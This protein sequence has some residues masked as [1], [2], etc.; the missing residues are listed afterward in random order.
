MPQ[1]LIELGGAG[2]LL[3][4]APA[5]GFPPA[6]YQPIAAALADS[7]RSVCL[8]PR[9]LWGGEPPSVPGNWPE[10][11]DDIVR[12]LA[13]HDLPP[14]IAIG[15]SFGAVASLVAAVR[16]P[17]RFRALVLLD[18][19]VLTGPRLDDWGRAKLLGWPDGHP[20]ALRA[21]E[22]R[23]RFGSHREAFDYWRTKRLFADW[24][25]AALEGYVAAMLVPAPDG[26]GFVLAWPKAWEAYYYESF[27]PG[28]WDDVARLPR[29]LPVLVIGGAT[30]DTFLPEAA[31]RFA[32][33]VP[34]ATVETM[35]A[36][37]HLFPQAAPAET[38]VRLRRWLA[39][40]S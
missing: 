18:P 35:P 15:H 33:A 27:Y 32:A 34:W 9:A 22:R 14:V 28:I 6:T 36:F 39:A 38:A 20:L 24:P 5:N 19:T 31:A 40:C 21:R 26:A 11:G 13:A 29:D 10:L 25:D 16:A 30:S 8:P 1:P 17:A 23:D 3:H 12:G 4:W 37:G 2:P 7:F